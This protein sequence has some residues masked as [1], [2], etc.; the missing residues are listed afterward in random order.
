MSKDGLQSEQHAPPGRA[1]TSAA[2]GIGSNESLQPTTR[3]RIAADPAA[4][5][6]E[7][8][9]GTCCQLSCSSNKVPQPAGTL[10]THAHRCSLNCRPVSRHKARSI[11][12]APNCLTKQGNGDA[13]RCVVCQASV[14][15]VLDIGRPH[16]SWRKL[17]D[18]VEQR[19]TG[20]SAQQLDLLVMRTVLSLGRLHLRW[21][22]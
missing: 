13:W 17:A 6:F 18:F 21:S 5:E 15:G 9:H 14:W 4:H 8:N 11:G 12:F 16:L 20:G 2:C 22:T 1:C 10:T 7:K 19:R 3:R